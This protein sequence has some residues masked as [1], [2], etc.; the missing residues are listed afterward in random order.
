[1]K[2]ALADTATFSTL[3]QFVFAFST[4]VYTSAMCTCESRANASTQMAAVGDF[5][6]HVVS[7]AEAGVAAGAVDE[8]VLAF[9]TAS[10]APTLNGVWGS[11]SVDPRNASHTCH[12]YGDTN[13]NL[14]NMD[15]L[16]SLQQEA[17][18]S[19]FASRSKPL[20]PFITYGFGAVCVKDSEPQYV[21]ASKLVAA[22]TSAGHD[23]LPGRCAVDGAML[24]T[25][26]E[27]F[28]KW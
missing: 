18:V 17:F 8:S 1:M 19:W 3:S 28:S 6:N 24:A 12:A 21:Y 14:E 15:G 26:W 2:A 5:V 9:L 13:I 22:V 10:Y 16:I 4:E 7:L 23:G 27:D 11:E 25:Q 20:P